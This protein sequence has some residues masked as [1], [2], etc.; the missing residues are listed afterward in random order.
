MMAPMEM[1]ASR[2]TLK[3]LCS[4][5]FVYVLCFM[6]LAQELFCVITYSREE[7]LDI[8]AA[9][10]HQNFQHYDQNYDFPGADPLFTLA[11]AIKCLPEAGPKQQQRSRGTRGSLLVRVFY[12][13]MS[14]LWTI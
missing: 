12:S 13:L 14:N 11:R 5:L 4:I 9:V 1:A 8:R 2:L 3:Q 10:T 6:L 7:L